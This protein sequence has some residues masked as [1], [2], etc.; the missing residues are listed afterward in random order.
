[1]RNDISK[2]SFNIREYFF[3]GKSQYNISL[4][5]QIILPYPILNSLRQ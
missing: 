3:V 5:L 4:Q 1:M 2:N